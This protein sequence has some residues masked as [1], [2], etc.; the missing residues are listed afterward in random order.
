MSSSSE[1]EPVFSCLL[2]YADVEQRRNSTYG[3][4]LYSLCLRKQGEY[5]ILTWYDYSQ[6]FK[7]FCALYMYSEVNAILYFSLKLM[8]TVKKPL[9]DASSRCS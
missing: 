1:E 9:L 7:T 6:I 2:R 5:H 8:Q 4:V 3:C